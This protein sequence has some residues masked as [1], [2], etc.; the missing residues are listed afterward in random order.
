MIR[1]TGGKVKVIKVMYL[2]SMEKY[3]NGTA[4]VHLPIEEWVVRV[5]KEED[6][7]K[8]RDQINPQS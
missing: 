5:R 3:K 6:V 8:T 4:H 7:T 1:E 2:S